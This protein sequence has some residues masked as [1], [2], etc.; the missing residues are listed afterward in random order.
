MKI[1]ASY[2]LKG[3]VG[4]T[5]AAVNLAF[6][7]SQALL[8][9]L[10][11]DLD[12]QGASSYYFRV[13]ANKKLNSNRFL[14]KPKQ[15]S[16]EVKASDFDYLDLLPASR[17]FRHFDAKLSEFGQN[18]RLKKALLPFKREYDLLFLDCPPSIGLLSENVFEASDYILVPVIPTTLSELTF[19]E[20]MGFF[21]DK[22]YDQQK[23]IPYFNM[24]QKQRNMHKT[25][26][27]RM[28]AT[29][30]Q[31]LPTEIPFSADIEN[32]GVNRAP[33]LAYAANKPASQAYYALW[34]EFCRLKLNKE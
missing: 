28:R 21:K 13:R 5:A 18:R 22:G 27:T 10:L 12:P 9:T 26:T 16:D 2:S 31:I 4:K 33:I 24:V 34:Q 20:L 11:V 3:G 14:V 30:S 32:M 8:R 15:L 17:S 6:A 7:A 29:Y 25:T 19:K 23:L 1:I